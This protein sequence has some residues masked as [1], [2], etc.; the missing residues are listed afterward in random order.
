MKPDFLIKTRFDFL[1]IITL[2]FFIILLSF[3]SR[4]LEANT[5]GSLLNVPSTFA[6]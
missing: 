4:I 5:T 1:V 2:L 3:V 6:K